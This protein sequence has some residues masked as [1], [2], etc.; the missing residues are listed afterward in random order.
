MPLIRFFEILHITKSHSEQII[1]YSGYKA[2]LHP[3]FCE[4]KGFARGWLGG[5][6]HDDQDFGQDDEGPGPKIVP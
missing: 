6:V 5:A 1:K 4:N 2:S 3:G